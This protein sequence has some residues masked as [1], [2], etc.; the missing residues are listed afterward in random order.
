MAS[1]TT[2]VTYSDRSTHADAFYT[3]ANSSTADGPV[4]TG[5]SVGWGH[6]WVLGDGDNV[7]PGEV[8]EIYVNVQ[9]IGLGSNTPFKMELIP[10]KGA[11]VTIERTTPLEIKTIMDLD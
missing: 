3:G 6:T 5:D 2:L 1:S 10:G 8:V 9:Q 4:G 11:V 7:D